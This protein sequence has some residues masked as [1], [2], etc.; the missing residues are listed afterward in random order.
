MELKKDEVATLQ[1]GAAHSGLQIDHS[2]KTVE[3]TAGFR[4]EE[5][6]REAEREKQGTK[7]SQLKQK[8]NKKQ[9]KEYKKSL[10]KQ[11]QE[12]IGSRDE[13]LTGRRTRSTRSTSNSSSASSSADPQASK[14]TLFKSEKDLFQNIKDDSSG[15]KDDDDDEEENEEETGGG[16]GNGGDEGDGDESATYTPNTNRSNITEYQVD[17]V[18]DM[19]VNTDKLSIDLHFLDWLENQNE[20]FVHNFKGEKQVMAETNDKLVPMY[21]GALNSKVKDE[22]MVSFVRHFGMLCHNRTKEKRRSGRTRSSNEPDDTK[23]LTKDYGV[24]FLMYQSIF[25]NRQIIEEKTSKYGDP[26]RFYLEDGDTDEDGKRDNGE[27]DGEDGVPDTGWTPGEGVKSET[28]Y[29][30]AAFIYNPNFTKNL[31]SNADS[32]KENA[33]PAFR[34]IL[35][36]NAKTAISAL[37]QDYQISKIAILGYG[38]L[39]AGLTIQTVIRA[40]LDVSKNKKREKDAE[41]EE[42]ADADI[43]GA[44]GYNRIYCANYLAIATSNDSSLDKQL[45]IAGRTFAELK[46]HAAPKNWHIN[47]L[48]VPNIVDTLTQYSEM[49]SILS[50]INTPVALMKNRERWKKTESDAPSDPQDEQSP[51]APSVVDSTEQQSDVRALTLPEALKESFDS[52]LMT[53]NAYGDLGEVGVRRGDFA[54]ILG[55]TNT[56]AKQRANA[57]LQARKAANEPGKRKMNRAERDAFAIQFLAQMNAKEKEAAEEQNAAEQESNQDEDEEKGGDEDMVTQETA[58]QVANLLAEASTPNTP[59]NDPPSS[60]SDVPMPEFQ[61]GTKRP[62][63]PSSGSSTTTKAPKPSPIN[64]SNARSNVGYFIRNSPNLPGMLKNARGAKL[65]LLQEIVDFW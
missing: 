32:Q 10:R 52:V 54:S 8:K 15:A 55:L 33:E 39:S 64:A 20:D 26:I 63:S 22:H 50:D 48:G 11:Q 57:A 23:T 62:T 2:S 44:A 41:R 3:S 9:T 19:H 51:N 42:I 17:Q 38:M 13:A 56:V 4:E 45:Q 35:F 60:S 59:S 34:V 46:N 1:Y 65:K 49:E 25:K 21:L 28:R 47:V 14:K 16:G 37:W 31:S 24:A 5:R 7:V 36:P 58:N 27:I 12:A 43:K 40:P 53:T 18:R 61:Q 6:A 29:S 30:L